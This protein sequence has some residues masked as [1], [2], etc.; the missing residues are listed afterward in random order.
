M[1]KENHVLH[2]LG[3]SSQQ[4]THIRLVKGVVRVNPHLQVLC[5]T[6]AEGIICRK[7]FKNKRGVYRRPK[8]LI[9]NHGDPRL[10][11]WVCEGCNHFLLR[12]N[13][14]DVSLI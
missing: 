13:M 8:L 9:K 2:L 14:N 11:L 1:N 12:V 10:Q 7:G 5:P 3:V 4:A 6:L